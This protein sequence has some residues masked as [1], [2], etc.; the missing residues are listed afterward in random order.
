MSEHHKFEQIGQARPLSGPA[1]FVIWFLGLYFLYVGISATVEVLLGA[2]SLNLSLKVEVLGLWL[3]AGLLRRLE[4][5]RKLTVGVL[6]VMLGLAVWGATRGLWQRADTAQEM[7][8]YPLAWTLPWQLSVSAWALLGLGAYMCQHILRLEETRGGFGR[9]SGGMG[10]TVAALASFCMLL[11]LA[12]GLEQKKVEH[13]IREIDRHTANL[14]VRDALTQEPLNAS[15]SIS[16]VDLDRRFQVQGGGGHWTI[17]WLSTGPLQV[18][19]IKEGFT[20]LKLTL[21]PDRSAIHK[22]EMMPLE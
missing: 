3:G 21:E 16:E 18:E 2:L 7:L 20:P 9:S 6:W 4:R 14:Q 8:G 10:Y 12:Q 13:L 5:W 15:I 19:L 17:S 11:I 22:V 1:T